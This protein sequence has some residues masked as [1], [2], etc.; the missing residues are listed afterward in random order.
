MEH[1]TAGDSPALEETPGTGPQAGFITAAALT[2][3]AG[4]AVEP[5]APQASKQA[6]FAMNSVA[7]KSLYFYGPRSFAALLLLGFVV[8]VLPLISA[9]IYASVF[10]ERLAKQSQA[11]V[12]EAAQATGLSR[13][14]VDQLVEMER[15]ARQYQVLRDKQLFQAYEE[16]HS[17]MQNTAVQLSQLVNDPAVHEHLQTLLQEEADQ[18][19]TLKSEPPNSKKSLQAVETFLSLRETA[20]SL[21]ALNEKSIDREVTAMG[22]ATDHALQVLVWI[23]FALAPVSLV[24]AAIFTVI[25]TRPIKQVDRAIRQLGDGKFNAPIRVTGP[26]DLEYLGQRLDWLRI[27][28]MDVEKQK[29]RFIQHVSHELKTPLTALREGAEL[30]GDEVVGSLRR[31]QREVVRIVQQNSVRLQKLIEDLLH[32]NLAIYHQ[33]PTNVTTVSLH[34]LLT[35]ALEAHKL[36]MVAKELNLKLE[37]DTTF[38]EGDEERLRVIADNLLSNAIKYSPQGGRL[39]L[40]LKN[41]GS[42][43]VL[44]VKDSGPGIPEEERDKLFD[45]FYHGAAAEAGHV[46]GSG[47]G[48]SIAREH[49]LAHDGTIQIVPSTRGAHFRVSLPL[50]HKGDGHGS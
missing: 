38:V 44:D 30:L 28:L 20:Q 18:Y 5:S 23:A 8:V 12:Y 3:G 41:T 21:L 15:S 14:L 45:A 9:L 26:R 16:K 11:T 6:F 19:T 43:A 34:K 13:T 10:V 36:T 39:L 4:R 33:R 25:L 24:L 29:T 7:P 46:K 42:K 1:T 32:F 2:P 50:S 31:E 47:L 48:L 37:L 49:V 40:T 22:A 17:D 27:R 35:R